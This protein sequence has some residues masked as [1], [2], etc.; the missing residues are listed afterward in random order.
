M[1]DYADDGIYHSDSCLSTSISKNVKPDEYGK[2]VHYIV[3]PKGTKILYIEGITTTKGEYE[4]LLDK[5]I[6]LKI[7]RN[8]S[9]FESHWKVV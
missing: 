7:I 5:N 8:K 9:E 6:D 4:L 1:T 2:Y 3:I